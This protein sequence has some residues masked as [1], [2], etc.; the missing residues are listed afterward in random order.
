MAFYWEPKEIKAGGKRDIGYGYGQGIV[1]APE[2]EGN[3]DVV[4]GGS[5][6]PGKLFTISAVVNDPAV[7]QTLR[8]ELPAGMQLVE[9]KERQPVLQAAQEDHPSLVLWKARVL[10][11]GQFTLRIR[12]STGVTQTKI[13]T[14]TPR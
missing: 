4:L 7:G 11:T 14:I 2:S 12:S 13:I 1:P 9:G 10:Q 3:C 6:E 8:L 5:F